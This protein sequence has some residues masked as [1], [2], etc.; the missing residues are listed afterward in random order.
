MLSVKGSLK[1]H[2]GWWRS[3]INNENVINTVAEG[4]RLPLLAIL[5]PEFLKNNKSAYD[6]DSFVNQEVDKLLDSGIVTKVL[7]KPTVINAL[8]VAIQANGKK[9]LSARSQISNSPFKYDQF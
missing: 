7:E 1:Q 8:S 9:T 5:K 6:N 2:L 3:H 4:Y